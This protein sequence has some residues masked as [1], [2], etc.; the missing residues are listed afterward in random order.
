[1]ILNTGKF[2]VIFSS[3]SWHSEGILRKIRHFIEKKKLKFLCM[4]K[5]NVSKFA[6]L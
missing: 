1:M 4:P 2:K 5:D 3:L 6:N